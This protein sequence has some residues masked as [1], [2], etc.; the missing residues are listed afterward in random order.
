MV[1]ECK[2]IRIIIITIQIQTCFT[3]F[4][5]VCIWNVC[6]FGSGQIEGKSSCIS[7]SGVKNVDRA[8]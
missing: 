2:I 1:C 3:H 6:R 7:V 5:I 4:C 8:E